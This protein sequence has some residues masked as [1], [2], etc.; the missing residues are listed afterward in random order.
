MIQ[1]EIY[2]MGYARALCKHTASSFHPVSETDTPNIQIRTITH[3]LGMHNV[4]CQL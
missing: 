3:G 4:K 1:S 2:N